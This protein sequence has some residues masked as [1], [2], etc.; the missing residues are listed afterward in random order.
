MGTLTAQKQSIVNDALFFTAEPLYQKDAFAL[1]GIT[2]SRFIRRA[3]DCLPVR[4]IEAKH[5]KRHSVVYFDLTQEECEKM[6]HL[7]FVFS[8]PYHL[9]KQKFSLQAKYMSQ[10]YNYA[11]S[12][13]FGL[14][15]S[16]NESCFYDIVVKY[17]FSVRKK[18]DE[19]F[20]MKQTGAW[21]FKDSKTLGINDLFVMTWSS[22]MASDFFIS[23]ML[24]LRAKLTIG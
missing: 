3:S 1:Q 13:Y 19:R 23:G 22:L 9:G 10:Y 24:H 2:N 7:G 6:C 5:P 14:Y 16:T 8:E 18:P 15:L 20:V 4:V 21:T 11:Y 12:N 17:E